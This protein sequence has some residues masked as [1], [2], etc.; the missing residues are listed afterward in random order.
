M[1]IIPNYYIN[2]VDYGFGQLA[3]DY[4]LETGKVYQFTGTHHKKIRSCTLPF[5]MKYIINMNK[6]INV[7]SVSDENIITTHD[8][9]YSP[10]EPSLNNII[11]YNNDYNDYIENPKQKK[12]M[13]QS[14]RSI[15]ETLYNYKQSIKDKGG[16][17][18]SRCNIMV[19]VDECG[20]TTTNN[21]NPA[22]VFKVN[23]ENIY[24][25]VATW[26]LTDQQREELLDVNEGGIILFSQ[27]NP[28]IIGGEKRYMKLVEGATSFLYDL[29]DSFT[30][31]LTQ[32]CEENYVIWPDKNSLSTVEYVVPV[33]NFDEGQSLEAAFERSES[34]DTK[35]IYAM[36]VNDI[37]SFEIE[38]TGYK[39][40]CSE[41]KCISTEI[42]IGCCNKMPKRVYWEAKC[43][44]SFKIKN[45]IEN[46]NVIIPGKG[47]R[48]ILTYLLK[49][50]IS[51]TTS[52]FQEMAEFYQKTLDGK[53]KITDQE[54]AEEYIT[55]CNFFM[56][57]ASTEKKKLRFLVS[58]KTAYGQIYDNIYF[59]GF[60][61]SRKRKRLA[62]LPNS[63]PKRSKTE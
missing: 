36:D 10:F 31:F 1:K 13:I 52:E 35:V 63:P 48:I 6:F 41:C 20:E 55:A 23:A 33:V 8:V 44:A 7:N 51:S 62:L 32:H 11:S 47:L 27:V 24:F 59:D 34:I 9:E 30:K 50:D 39:F 57:I 46:Y 26:N 18:L 53:I 37:K 4:K 17:P 58:R 54:Q 29:S 61:N 25:N 19:K 49:L 43:N 60:M 15:F 28:A 38:E 56:N 21:N 16:K 45:K 2:H 14:V 22:F 40:W 3:V 12:S 42:N 5:K